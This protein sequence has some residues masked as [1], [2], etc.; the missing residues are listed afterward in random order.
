MRRLL[1]GGAAGSSTE[2]RAK[3]EG[4]GPEAEVERLIGSTDLVV[5]SSASCPF[6]VKALAALRDAVQV[7]AAVI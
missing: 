4:G 5:F 3:A 7:V 1:E 6:C 2:G